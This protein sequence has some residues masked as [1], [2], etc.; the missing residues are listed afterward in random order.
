[1]CSLHERVRREKNDLFLAA[2]F[3]LF[4][5]FII[6]WVVFLSSAGRPVED[7][8]IDLSKEGNDDSRKTSFYI[9][10]VS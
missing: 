9:S 1:M 4:L 2:A 6:F 8:W 10:V 7:G 3:S 5:V